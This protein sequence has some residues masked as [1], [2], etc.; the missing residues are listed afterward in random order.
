MNT[1]S[2]NINP[3][4]AAPPQSAAGKQQDSTSAD[5]PFSQVLSSEMA[6]NRRNSEARQGTDGDAGKDAAAQA[7]RPTEPGERAAAQATEA[8]EPVRD[9]LVP[10]LAEN[11]KVD[12]ATLLGLA[13]TPDQLKPAAAKMDSADADQPTAENANTLPFQNSRKGRSAQAELFAGTA[14]DTQKIDPALPGKASLQASTT[15]ALASAFSGQLAAAR[16]GDAMKGEF[17]SD[18]TS[19]PA[20]RPASQASFET[21]HTLNEVAAPKLAPTLGTTAW[22]Q[23]LGEKVV[24]MAA[25][26]QQTATLTLNPP[27]MGPL[28]IVLN[29]A[30]DQATASFFSAQPEVR[31]AL[32]AAFPRLKEMMNE[33]GIQL[34]QA[35]VSADTPR[36]DNPSDQQAQRV[37]P[38]F[39]GRDDGAGGGMQTLHLPP[40]QSGR[41]LVDTFA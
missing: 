24:W 16:Q 4:N 23:A 15:A 10:P 35:T 7:G 26:A 25:G 29:V 41:G 6:Q 30:N 34:E 36:Q 19:N 13:I 32:E 28:Q 3:V 20:M 22:N 31:Q 5:V 18:L 2:M 17:M 14:R 39:G 38:P 33:A 8:A 40:Q 9:P 1:P 11:A 27:N 37:T 21:L 12:P